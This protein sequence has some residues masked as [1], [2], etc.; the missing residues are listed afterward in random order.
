MITTT[1]N[2]SSAIKGR[3]WVL[4]DNKEVSFQVISS[5]DQIVHGEVQNKAGTIAFL[6]IFV[7]AY[8]TREERLPLWAEL[9]R[10]A[11]STIGI[12]LFLG[13]FNSVLEA[14]DKIG[15][16]AV[17][18]AECDDFINTVADCQLQELRYTVISL[19]NEVEVKQSA[20]MLDPLNQSLFQDVKSV[21]SEYEKWS[22]VEEN[23]LKQKSKVHW[24]N[25]GDGNNKFFHA[26][27]KARGRSGISVLFD[28]LGNKLV[29]D[30]DIKREIMSFY[31]KLLG[32]PAN[33]SLAVDIHVGSMPS[34]A[35]QRML[36]EGIVLVI[37]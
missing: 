6:V 37:M 27:L 17:T 32:T 35:T 24:L 12:W 15:G 21:Q 7:Y 26:S 29:E 31:Q 20:V 23:I 13:D 2:Y 36:S 8:N 30:V 11:S 1:N 14:G 9:R 19:R 25:C 10:I 3:I 28:D 5:T 34:N 22:K 18:A 4:W 33:T 16:N